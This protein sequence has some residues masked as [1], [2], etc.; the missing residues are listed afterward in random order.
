MF[1]DVFSDHYSK[2]PVSK[3]QHFYNIC[4]GSLS[5]CTQGNI[6]LFHFLP[7]RPHRLWVKFTLGAFDFFN[8]FE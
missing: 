1:H 2:N 8:V 4:Q 7:F 6:A 5:S 3:G